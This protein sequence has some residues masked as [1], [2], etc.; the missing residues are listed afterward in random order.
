[1]DLGDLSSAL[2]WWWRSLL[3]PLRP[4]ATRTP[5]ATDAGTPAD[6]GVLALTC[7]VVPA[8]A[9]DAVDLACWTARHVGPPG[10]VLVH[11]GGRPL[12][13]EESRDLYV[14]DRAFDQVTWIRAADPTTL[15]LLDEELRRWW[16][17]GVAGAR[18]EGGHVSVSAPVG[19]VEEGRVKVWLQRIVDART[20]RPGPTDAVAAVRQGLGGPPSDRRAHLL[21]LLLA[22]DPE[23]A[24]ELANEWLYGGDAA[25]RRAAA[26]V[27][28]YA[29][30]L[31]AAL[32]DGE[33]PEEE[34]GDTAE[35]LARS[36]DSE[37][38][39]RGARALVEHR[40]AGPWRRFL[41]AL[42][43]SPASALL[44]TCG[45][46]GLERWPDKRRHLARVAAHWTGA[47]AER[48]L[49][50]LLEDTDTHVAVGAAESL[51]RSGTARSLGALR[52]V[53]LGGGPSAKAAGAACER[54]RARSDAMGGSLTHPDE[55][56][57]GALSEVGTR[58]RGAVSDT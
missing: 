36:T 42:P 17:A 4:P 16:S 15:A 51:G 37:A 30:P 50:H 33:V 2:L 53:A 56:V 11:T 9:D 19:S 14:G 12:P 57:S 25:E 43:E 29:A 28:G 47:S 31:A 21:D 48:L 52:R 20:L 10:I 8:E 54:I 7:T 55:P 22:H 6:D 39:V 35:H 45:A 34:L 23:R 32:Q 38:L 26:R 13:L 40:P 1:M 44:D 18:L 46:L 27:L 49:L 24:R 58:G 3:A 5:G 41:E